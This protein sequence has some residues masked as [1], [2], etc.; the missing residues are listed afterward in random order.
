MRKI[1]VYEDVSLDLLSDFIGWLRHPYGAKKVIP[2]EEVAAVRSERTVNIILTCVI[3][4]YD[5][6]LRSQDYQNKI[7]KIVKTQVSGNHRKFKSFLH[8][9][10]KGKPV[11]K[12][13]LKLNE[14]KRRIKTLSEFQ[15]KS[16]HDTC[17]NTRDSLLLLVLYEGGLRISEALSLWIEDFDIGK[18]AITVRKSKTRAGEGRKVFVTEKT[19]N[20]FQDFLIDFHADDIDTN[21]VFFKLTGPNRGQHLDYSS[22]RSWVK[23][24]KSKTGIDFTT[25][26]FRHTYATE[27]LRNGV[28]IKTLQD[29]LG[30]ENV[31]TTIGIYLH[32]SDDDIR[33]EWEKAHSNKMKKLIEGVE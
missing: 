9:I 19:M 28:N 16:I 2:F 31:Q 12:N 33:K 8:H 22:T 24:M 18:N 3:G 23:R 4:F 26:M 7:S 27:L 14:P 29:L 5:Y 21:Y 20:L 13:I 11:D 17:T 30:H 1:R 15:I 32:P 25:H 10:T 6:L